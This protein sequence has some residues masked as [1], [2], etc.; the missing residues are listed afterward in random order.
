M[1]ASCGR[2][3]GAP[4]RERAAEVPSLIAFESAAG[5]AIERARRSGGRP[6]LLTCA[7]TRWLDA[8]LVVVGASGRTSYGRRLRLRR[9]AYTSAGTT[10]GTLIEYSAETGRPKLTAGSKR[11]LRAATTAESRMGRGVMGALYV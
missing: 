5:S 2:R 9:S 7:G 8:G 1:H 11:H 4:G 3:P 6:P 10:T